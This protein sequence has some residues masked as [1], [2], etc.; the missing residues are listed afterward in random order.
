METKKQLKENR[1][2]TIKT[3]EHND[4]YKS[5]YESWGNGYVII[6]QVHPLYPYIISRV[7][8]WG[9]MDILCGEEIT[10]NDYYKNGYMIG[11]DTLH[12]YNGKH[13]N[14]EWVL[15]KC[16]EIRIYLDKLNEELENNNKL[17]QNKNV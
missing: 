4:Y 17:K 9:F 1:Q 15:S 6:P 10:F 3:I 5:E 12:T 2:I 16:N 7:D 8:D 11:F 14:Q 13:N